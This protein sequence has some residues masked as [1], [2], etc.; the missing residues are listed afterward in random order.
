MTFRSFNIP[1]EIICERGTKGFQKN[2]L[3]YLFLSV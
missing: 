2:V 1:I 3:S